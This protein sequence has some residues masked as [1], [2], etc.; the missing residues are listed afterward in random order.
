M[1]DRPETTDSTPVPTLSAK[2][3]IADW[4]GK[5]GKKTPRTKEERAAKADVIRRQKELQKILDRNTELA[6]DN[7]RL[8]GEVDSF[9][10]NRSVE[11]QLLDAAN[12]L[13][14]Q[15][16]Y[17]AAAA[18]R[19]CGQLKVLSGEE[20][21]HTFGLDAGET[22]KGTVVNRLGTFTMTFAGKGSSFVGRL[23][24]DAANRRNVPVLDL[25]ENGL[26][27]RVTN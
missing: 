5:D 25:D 16:L 23:E 20:G 24:V 4:V 21:K 22:L 15:L 14:T 3:F 9:K 26:L 27:P 12:Q 13:P 6:A 1:S 17:Y 7:Q 8:Q 19:V 10:A 11:R 2:D 18:A